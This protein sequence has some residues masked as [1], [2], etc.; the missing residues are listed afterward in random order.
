[1]SVLKKAYEECGEDDDKEEEESESDLL[2]REALENEL[3]ATAWRDG[4][5][6][7][8]QALWKAFDFFNAELFGA[9]LP[10]VMVTLECEAETVGFFQSGVFGESMNLT[11][12]IF[13][14]V[15]RSEFF[16]RWSMKWFI[17]G[18]KPTGSRQSPKIT[19]GNGRKR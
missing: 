3:E 15:A 17:S 12:T 13:S 9:S 8:C 2:A 14:F 6:R 10:Y 1:M 11:L 7:V 18:R 4:V 19:T 5:L 16:R